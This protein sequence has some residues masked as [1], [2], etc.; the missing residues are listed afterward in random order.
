VLA[1]R[2][3]VALRKDAKQGVGAAAEFDLQ[4]FL[5][6]HLNWKARLR[7][8]VRLAE[9]FDVETVRKDDCC[10]LGQWLHGK[11]RTQWGHL[12]GLTRLLD[13]HA[14]FHREAGR[15]AEVANRGDEAGVQRL[16]G[17][18]SAFSRATQGTVMALKG[19]ELEMRG[20]A[21]KAAASR[22]AP[23]PRSGLRAVASTT[24]PV[25]A[26][27]AAT[28]TPADDWETF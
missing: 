23:A 25:P 21:P 14:A 7:D 15:V 1:E 4:T 13:E 18:G 24:S 5:S 27:A 2:D 17:T 20:A 11:G 19:F 16:L 6:A 28:A 12:P 22:P 10:P 8:A 3:A 26:A 9:K